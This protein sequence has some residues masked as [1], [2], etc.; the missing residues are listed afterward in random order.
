VWQSPRPSYKRG[1]EQSP[2]K[3]N[4]LKEKKKGGAGSIEL[5]HVKRGRN[6]K[7][8]GGT[9]AD[10]PP[11]TKIPNFWQKAKVS[12]KKRSLILITSQA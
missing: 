5:S 6:R 1:Q 7:K 12:R 8:E 3:I 9:S 4:A 10:W 11:I 2:R